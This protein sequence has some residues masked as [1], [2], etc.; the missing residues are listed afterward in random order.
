MEGVAHVLS[1]IIWP[2]LVGFALWLFKT[3]LGGLLEVVTARL[4]RRREGEG[5]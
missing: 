5:S 3:P 1:V 4:T 2:L